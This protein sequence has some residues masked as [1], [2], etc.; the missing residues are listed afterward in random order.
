MSLYLA[1]HL[2]HENKCYNTLI[3][4][5]TFILKT[6]LNSN[7]IYFFPVKRQVFFYNVKMI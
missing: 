5:L 2:Q 3:S 4:S 6:P 1:A 7:Y